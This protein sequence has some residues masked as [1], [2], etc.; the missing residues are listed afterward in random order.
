MEN[1]TYAMLTRQSGL[2]DELS[3]I[4]HNIAN[5]STAGF[6]REGVVFSEYVAQLDGPGGSLSMAAARARVV[7]LAQAPLAQTGGSFDFAIDG[8]G[9]FTVETP[10]GPRL[11]RAGAF[12]PNAQG[13]LVTAD[14]HRL[15][16]AGG[17]PVFIPPDAAAIAL[18]GDGT[19]SAD[20]QPLTQLGAVAPADPNDLTHEAGTLFNPG[21]A[22]LV[23]VE[24]ARF[25]QGFL[26]G[27]NVSPIAEIA[28]MIEVQRAYEL[29][30]G[31]LDRED[32]RIR[33]VIRTL[34]A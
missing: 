3:V 26:E 32:D 14:G 1:A 13:D 9:F 12:T 19:L 8:P 25:A 24:G 33:N 18:G 17:A 27:S 28:R 2:K 21:T 20:G 23:P 31:L 22:D 7:D 5:A 16:D 34:S 11:T 6:R 4:A 30:R 15:L 10:A 29:G